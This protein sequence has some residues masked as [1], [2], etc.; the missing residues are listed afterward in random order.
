[1]SLPLTNDRREFRKHLRVSEQADHTGFHN[2]PFYMAEHDSL[3]AQWAN[4]LY[5]KYNSAFGNAQRPSQHQ[6][7]EIMQKTTSS[8]ANTRR[9]HAPISHSNAALAVVRSQFSINRIRR[10]SRAAPSTLCV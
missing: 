6:D 10:C 1:M 9:S 8:H 7:G 3:H 5:A 4:G 2:Y